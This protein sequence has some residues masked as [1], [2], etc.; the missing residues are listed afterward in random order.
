MCGTSIPN[1]IIKNKTDNTV[2]ATVWTNTV[3]K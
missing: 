1:K 3:E 2:H